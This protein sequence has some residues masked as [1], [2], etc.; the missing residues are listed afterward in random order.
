MVGLRPGIPQKSASRGGRNCPRKISA[1]FK[2]P[3]RGG[4]GRG[5]GKWY[6]SDLRI[7]APLSGDGHGAQIQDRPGRLLQ[8]VD[9]V[10]C[11]ARH[12]H[13]HQNVAGRERRPSRLPH[14]ERCGDVRANCGRE[15]AYAALATSLSRT[16]SQMSSCTIVLR[17]FVASSLSEIPINVAWC[18]S[19]PKIAF[20]TARYMR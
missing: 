10:L 17:R 12:L 15:R 18:C 4:R 5:G 13:D 14:Q 2:T 6:D 20:G 19:W 11:R 3:S 1:I 8:T 9:Q 7:I 16:A